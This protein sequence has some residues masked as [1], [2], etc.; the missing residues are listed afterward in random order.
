M[1][2]SKGCAKILLNSLSSKDTEYQQVASQMVTVLQE[3]E[4]SHCLSDS[5]GSSP[6]A[7]RMHL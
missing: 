3:W 6:R 4:R 5:L 2:L 1:N 7:R